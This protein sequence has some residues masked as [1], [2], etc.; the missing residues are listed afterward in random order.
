LSE[1]KSRLKKTFIGILSE[2][3]KENLNDAE[4]TLDKKRLEELSSRKKET[5]Y[6]ISVYASAAAVRLAKEFIS[7]GNAELIFERDG[8]GKPYFKNTDGLFFSISHSFPHYAAAVSDKPVGIDIEKIRDVNLNISQRMFTENEK[9]YVGNDTVRFFEVWTKKEAYSKFTGKGLGEK[10][11][12]FDVLLPS[13]ADNFTF[14][15]KD[16]AAVA[17]YSVS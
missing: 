3:Y 14:E 11:S 5:E 1:G 6:A 4:K 9:E 13:L 2:N 7:D 17:V 15:I 8:R 16:G 10:F 12:S